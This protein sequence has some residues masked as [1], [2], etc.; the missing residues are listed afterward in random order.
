M[1]TQNSTNAFLPTNHSLSTGARMHDSRLYV[2]YSLFYQKGERKVCCEQKQ[3]LEGTWTALFQKRLKIYS[4]LQSQSQSQSQPIHRTNNAAGPRLSSPNSTPSS[5]H[6]HE[7]FVPIEPR[8]Q[9]KR[10]VLVSQSPRYPSNKNKRSSWPETVCPQYLLGAIS[11]LN[12]PERGIREHEVNKRQSL[13][14]AVFLR[15]HL[16]GKKPLAVKSSAGKDVPLLLRRIWFQFGI[17]VSGTYDVTDWAVHGDV[18]EG[19]EAFFG[20]LV[21]EV[22]FMG[23]VVRR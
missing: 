6:L 10:Q 7:N 16:S 13:A 21:R 4:K 5:S 15:D 22:A 17:F 12:H 3:C 8:N 1:T 11:I 19:S 23:E 9:G 20:G 14:L 2:S 18:V